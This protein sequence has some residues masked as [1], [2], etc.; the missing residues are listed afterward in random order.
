MAVERPSSAIWFV[1]R[2]KMQYYS[3]DCSP[4]STYRIRVKQAQIRDGVLLVVDLYRLRALRKYH[5]QAKMSQVT[6]PRRCTHPDVVRCALQITPGM[7]M[8]G[9]RNL[10]LGSAAG[11]LA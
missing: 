9:F 10:I 6:A 3:C 8:I 4:V 2:I 1:L 11:L 7:R 5:N